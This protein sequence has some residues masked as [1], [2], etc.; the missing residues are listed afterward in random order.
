MGDVI[1][2]NLDKVILLVLILAFA[3]ILMHASAHGNTELS[4]FASHVTDE[5]LGALLTLITGRA[6][7][8]FKNGNGSTTSST[9]TPQS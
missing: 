7:A 6:I 4:H 8:G 5:A 2:N 1:R 3:V 9:N